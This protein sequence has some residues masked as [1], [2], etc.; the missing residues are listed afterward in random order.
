VSIDDEQFSINDEFKQSAF[1]LADEAEL[2]E[3]EAVKC[4]LQSQE[5]V[6]I[7]GRSLLECGIIRFHQERKYILDIIRLLLELSDL[8]HFQ[9]GERVGPFSD[10]VDEAIYRT[11]SLRIVPRCVSAMDSI[12]A[13]IQRISDK[14][15]AFRVLAGDQAVQMTGE[16]ETMEH[17][18][19]S[20]IHQHEMLAVILCRSIEAGKAEEDDF[21]AFIRAMKQAERYDAFLG[22]PPKCKGG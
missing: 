15:A 11:G 9:D 20:L 19:T 5:D 6:A 10:Y 14:M 22:K 21:K 13:W 12:R 7:L 8:H 16:L 18:R 4:L 1:S 3:I 2:D 17:S